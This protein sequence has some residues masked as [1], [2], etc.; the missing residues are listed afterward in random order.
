MIFLDEFDALAPSRAGG[1]GHHYEAE[2]N[3]LL[4]QL[5][6]CAARRIL[7]VA[8]TNRPEKIDPAVLRPGR[9]DKQFFVGPPDLEAR[10]EL[11]RLCL[12]D[13][14]AVGVDY[15]RLGRLSERY[16]PAEIRAVVDDA[17]RVAL[18]RGNEISHAD[19]LQ[20]LAARPPLLR[21]DDVHRRIGFRGPV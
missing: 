6:E 3:E 11:L 15:L 9:F 16:T 5:N 2:V 13:R 17:A 21:P 12:A 18:T 20:A 7:V 14:P 10:V 4:T 1:S 8:A 19:V